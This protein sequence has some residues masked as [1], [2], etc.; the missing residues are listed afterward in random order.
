MKLS[1]LVDNNTYID[2]YFIGEPAVSYYIEV[3]GMNILFD[4]GYS[5]AFIKNAFKMN[6][7]LRML[8]YVILS[9]GHSDH[10]WGLDP[11][12]R[13]LSEASLESIPFKRPT[14]LS[15][16]TAYESK[17]F[18]GNE[19]GSIVS[20][21][22]MQKQFDLKFSKEPI[23]L[24]E[25]F[26]YLGEIE[27]TND[28]E[29]QNSIG[30][31]Y[32]DGK[33]VEDYIIDDTALVYKG[34]DGLVIIAGCSHAGICNTIEYAKKVT[35][36]SRVHDVIGGFHLQNPSDSQLAGTVEYFKNLNPDFIHACHCTD[37]NSKIAL[38]KV[39]NVK[40]VGVGLQ[41]EYK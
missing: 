5:D 25:R 33:L 21:S 38:A 7:N 20:A 30:K 18:E 1:V 10:T 36:E 11:F 37:L 41:L 27:K 14:F 35:G 22:K 32:I 23:Q 24:S 16:P 8:D 13:L 9:H 3:D 17:L 28:F 26:F 12:I 19:I 31:T 29:G 15:H 39:G 4:L 34:E 6:I 40:E 2:R